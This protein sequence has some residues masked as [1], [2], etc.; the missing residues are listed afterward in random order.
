MPIAFTAAK[1]PSLTTTSGTPGHVSYIGRVAMFDPRLQKRLDFTHLGDDLVYA[2]LSLPDGA[3]ANFL[4]LEH[5][6]IENDRAEMR[7]VRNLAG[8]LRPP[9]IGVALITALPP[10]GEIT[11]DEAIELAWQIAFEASR[12]NRLACYLVIHDP[13]LLVPGH[14]NRHAHAFVVTRELGDHGF[15]QRKCRDG[16]ASVRTGEG[17]NFV[18]EGVSWP[19]T[20]WRIQRTK[21]LEYGT[22]LVV[23]L[24]APHPQEHVRPAGSGNHTGRIAFLRTSLK[25]RNLAAIH[26]PPA[27]LLDALLR[28]RST[29]EIEELRGFVAKFI[30]SRF[31]RDAAI[32]RILSDPEIVTL[33]DTAN[34]RKPR[35]VTT[36]AIHAAIDYAVDLVDRSQEGAATIHTAVGADHAEVVAAINGVLEYNSLDFSESKLLIVGT[37]LSDCEEMATSLETAKPAV[38]TLSAVLASKQTKSR[39]TIR[40]ALPAGG[41]VIVPRAECVS[42]QDLAELLDLAQ[43]DDALAV[44]GK[45]LSVETGVVANR[46]VCYAVDRITSFRTISRLRISAERLLR[47]GLTT[48]AIKTMAASLS[49]EPLDKP[50]ADSNA[51]DFIVCTNAQA[52]KAANAKL[53]VLYGKKC[54]ARGDSSFVVDLAHGPAILWPLQ[55][56]VFTGTDYSVL[57]PKVREGQLATV[58][59]KDNRTSTVRTLLS[60]GRFVTIP[61]RKFPR[62]RS[63]FALSI[64]EIRQSNSAR[65]RIELGDVRRSWA[66][67]LLAATRYESA[68]VIIDPSVA[69]D[70]FSLA[71]A[72]SGSLPGALPTELHLVPDLNAE[73]SAGMAKL[74]STIEIE[75]P[76]QP[77]VPVPTR[78]QIALPVLLA[79]NVRDLLASDPHAARAV[80]LLSELLHPDRG[81]ADEILAKLQT[82]CSPDG[83][84]MHVVSQLVDAHQGAGG[85]G[86]KGDDLDMPR[87]LAIQSPRQF[88][89]TDLQLLEQDLLFMFFPG[90]Y[91]DITTIAASRGLSPA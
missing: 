86:Q 34:L 89:M 3:P 53:T 36:A 46:L 66:A 83:L 18:S 54:A 77:D 13:A 28:G 43:Q 47:A 61:T 59:S 15:A 17:A 14:V 74:I 51:F 55:P 44:L 5:F 11:L 87:E 19:D 32:D 76:P 67:L 62:L 1:F 64:R 23:D 50:P 20:N 52:L 26:G 12:R 35:F 68:S 42:D 45:D 7:R 84:T 69:R 88:T 73:I 39:R 6:S 9:Q 82:L 22:D 57:P 2:Q 16:I 91:L 27:V 24:I 10:D 8:S 41:L 71:I 21:L 29:I 79:D 65:L 63:G 31:D 60:D 49:F 48:A 70:A 37:R 75:T 81:C 4:D 30:D 56:I 78:S 58:L 38:A 90:S 40:R 80:D 33:A 25:S 85:T 72:L